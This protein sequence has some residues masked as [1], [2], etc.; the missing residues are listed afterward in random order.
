MTAYTIAG[1]GEILW[2]VFGDSEELGG[3]PINFA[4]HAGVLGARSYPISTVGDDLR[5][6]NALDELARRGVPSNHI[7]VA[8][9]GITGYV[10]ATVDAHGVASYRFPD[11]VAWDA[12]VLSDDTLSLAPTLDA[13]CFGSLAQ[14]SAAS[15]EAIRSFLDTTGPQTRKVFDINLR[16]HFYTPEVL[17]DSLQRAD[18]V[19]LNDEELQ[20]IMTMEQLSGDDLK[21]M[22]ILLERYELQLA[23]L[24]RG[25]K[26]SLLVSPSGCSD[27]PGLHTTIADTIG[28][29][30]SFTAAIVM[31]FLKK[32]PL[33]VINEHAT[34]VATYVCSQK[35]AMPA[36]PADLRLG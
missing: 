27:H 29:G 31:G 30:D 18:I 34:R 15:R 33:D 4:Y 8:E 2:D 24:T 9:G 13:V 11:N 20:I 22:Q 21:V 35:G 6:Q 1:I 23:A 7:S 16:Q 17:R 12:I 5:G 14:R 25:D 3:A 28:A 32:R 10:Q 36:L 26:G 19:K